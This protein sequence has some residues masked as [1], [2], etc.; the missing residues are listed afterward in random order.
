MVALGRMIILKRFAP[1]NDLCFLTL[2]YDI[3]KA[4]SIDKQAHIV[5]LYF[6]IAEEC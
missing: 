6:P 2:S 1:I 5:G 4:A 3:D